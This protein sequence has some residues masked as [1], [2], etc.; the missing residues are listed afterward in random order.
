MGVVSKKS[1]GA[2]MTELNMPSWR[3]LQQREDANL[4]DEGVTYLAE[5]M[6]QKE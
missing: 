4:D 2:R 6:M 5:R 1:I 3:I